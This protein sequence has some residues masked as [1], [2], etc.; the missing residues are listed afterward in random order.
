M[1]VAVPDAQ[2]RRLVE[3]N[4]PEHADGPV[5]ASRIERRP[6]DRATSYALELLRVHLGAGEHVDVVVKDFST[7]RLPKDDP[8]GRAR[9]EVTV[10]RE[11][12]DGTDV[13]TPRLYGVTAQPVRLLLEHVD[14]ATLKGHD[15]EV[16]TEAAAWLGA[17]QTRIAS[18]A[19]QVRGCKVL[20][21]HDP[22]FFL[23]RATAARQ[24]IAAYGPSAAERLAIMLD[25]YDRLVEAMVDQPRTLVHGSFRPQNIIVAMERDGSV[26]I[27][28][29]DWE[30]SGLG[31]PLYDLA[32]LA[33]G[34]D[35]LERDRLFAA[36][37]RGSGRPW[38]GSGRD[39]VVP[40]DCFRLHKI[41]K[42]IGDAAMFAFRPA[43]VDKL[44][45]MG[46][47]LRERL[48]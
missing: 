26:R 43:T 1:T 11:L 41:V 31:S 29:V 39:M 37:L 22:P 27:C 45:A 42:S 17:F 21:R 9:R 16:W 33:E 6:F 25:G 5:S 3:S 30:L 20:L 38:T 36:Y 19:E 12:L 4:L 48:A 34:F 46:E 23:A 35:D 18:R 47:E 44:L 13:G 15:L 7:S 10:Y 2:L 14:G 24:S 32:F 28:P 8:A 40:I